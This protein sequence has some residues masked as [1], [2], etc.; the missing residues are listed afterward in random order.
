[1]SLGFRK[2]K[3]DCNILES[4]LGTKFLSIKNRNCSISFLLIDSYIDS[5]SESTYANGH[6]ADYLPYF[7][8]FIYHD[9]ECAL[10]NKIQRR[11]TRTQDLE[12]HS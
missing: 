9:L 5:K 7:L 8:F 4:Y 3:K 10:F 6:F 2:C 1:M 12:D 11:L